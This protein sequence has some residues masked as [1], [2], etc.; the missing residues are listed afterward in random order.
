MDLPRVGNID[1]EGKN[2]ILRADLDL[3]ENDNFRLKAS[4]KTYEYCIENKARLIIIGHKGRP[5]GRVDKRY[6]LS[7]TAKRLSSV[8]RIKVRFVK[9]ALGHKV[10][11]LTS[12]FQKED[13]LM[14]ENLRFDSREED[15]NEEFSKSLAS[16]ADIYINESFGNSHRKHAS[17]VGIPK[18]L[19]HAVGFRFRSEVKNLEKV[20]LNPKQPVIVLLS[21]V[22]RDKLSYLEGFKRFA[23]K[24]LI[25]GRLPEYLGEQKDNKLAI[26][27]LMPDKEDVTVNSI[28]DFESEIS[29]AG[30]IVV[31]GPMGKYED[32][33]HRLGTE[34]IL[35]KV[36]KSKAYKVAGGGDTEKAISLF[37]L[38]DRFDWISVGGGAMLE[39]LAKGTLP[40]IEALKT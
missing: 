15:N 38:N 5:R 22:K 16:I 21:G 27:Q 26:A 36:A 33:G 18:Y 4:L 19:P 20:F 29:S 14:L 2:V 39:F 30:T 8:L 25:A 7:K 3:P 13:V 40:G 23:K 6:S 32:E 31:S 37:K 17:I 11:K 10:K 24:I 34:R 1:I 9:T 28:E 12:D 35:K